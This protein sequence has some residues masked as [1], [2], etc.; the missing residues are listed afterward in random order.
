MQLCSFIFRST[1]VTVESRR[2][3]DK[4]VSL[5]GTGTENGAASTHLQ[6]H[7]F[8]DEFR[9]EVHRKLLSPRWVSFNLVTHEAFSSCGGFLIQIQSWLYDLFCRFRSVVRVRVA[10]GRRNQ[11]VNCRD[12]NHWT[13]SGNFTRTRL[14]HAKRLHCRARQ[15]QQATVSA[16]TTHRACYLL[17]LK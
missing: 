7:S 4:V 6:G 3:H 10:A 11:C 9:D 13:S 17:L 2:K 5:V 15:H 16:K 14:H 1:F 8:V 12:E